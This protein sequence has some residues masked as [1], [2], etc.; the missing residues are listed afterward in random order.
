M[1]M[2]PL[3]DFIR[4]SKEIGVSYTAMSLDALLIAIHLAGTL[5]RTANTPKAP[6]ICLLPWP[7]GN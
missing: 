5:T 7:L 2:P 6:R 4:K 3:P 1:Q